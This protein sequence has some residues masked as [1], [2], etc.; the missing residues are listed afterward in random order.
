MCEN[1]QAVE[2]VEFNETTWPS[3][4]GRVFTDEESGTASSKKLAASL[5]LECHFL[6]VSAC[7]HHSLCTR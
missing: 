3:D 7:S 5:R 2:F 6:W 4:A 1:V